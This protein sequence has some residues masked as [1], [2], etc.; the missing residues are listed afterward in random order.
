VKKILNKIK[1]VIQINKY[2]VFKLPS[3]WEVPRLPDFNLLKCEE[4]SPE[5]IVMLFK[6]DSKR[7]KLFLKFVK[8]GMKGIIHY[9]VDK[10]V[11]YAWMSCPG[12]PGPSHLPFVNRLKVYWI[13]YCR[14]QEGFQNQGLY[15]RSLIKLCEMA[16]KVDPFSEVYVDTKNDNLPSIR[17]I[18]KVGFKSDGF[19]ETLRISIPR[20]SFVI[21]KRWVKTDI[22]KKESNNNE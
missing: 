5:L 7:S 19:I 4:A 10:W 8:S 16:R 11:S 2:M 3:S 21:L 18:Q 1:K 13:H 20:F 12:T 6:D 17:A 9:D 14:T 15:K 22:S